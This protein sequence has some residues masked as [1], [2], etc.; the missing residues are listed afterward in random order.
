MRELQVDTSEDPVTSDVFLV[1]QLRT[2][3]DPW[4]P[5]LKTF[6]CDRATGAFIPFIPLLLSPQTTKI[7]I[8][9]ADDSSTMVIGPVISRFP[10]LCP[11]LQHITLR[12]IPRD[13]IITDAASEMLLACNRDILRVFEV[14]SPL[15]EE[16]REV[17]CKLP[18]LS[19]LWV[20][21]EGPTFLPAVAFP[22]L[23]TI[24]IEYDHELNW[25]QG[26]HGVTLAKLESVTFR[27]ESKQI[28]DFLGVF[29]S[30]ALTTFAQNT[31]S[32]FRFY[33]TSAWNPNYSPLLSFKQLQH[34]E[35]E[36]SCD[37]GCSSSVDDEMIISLA[38]AMPKLEILQ[39]GWDP[40]GLENPTGVTV[41]GL[42]GLSR[43]CPHLS[44][45]RIHF[46][47]ASLLNAEADATTSPPS[48]DERVVQREGCALTELA[49]GQIPIPAGSAPTIT[50]ILL[51]IFPRIL[52]VKYINPG[53]R[54]VAES[55]KRFR[56]IG[57]FVH[58]SGKAQRSHI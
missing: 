28:R 27:S 11:N 1:L 22:S 10:T 34:L 37:D 17:V 9:F 39:L 12:G 42:I 51:Q 31:L 24:D 43:R 30:V 25:L 14:D 23:T 50:L 13:S 36:F 20:V 7:T 3:N 19:D 18:R 49:A 29:E 2:A 52:D 8:G 45:L 38:R 15:T 33:T 53:W 55:I 54:A 56:R 26:L 4:L 6:E 32:M 58:R 57:A 35:I 44:K 5:R 48:D 40:C 16:A 41:N 21:I 47:A 46:H